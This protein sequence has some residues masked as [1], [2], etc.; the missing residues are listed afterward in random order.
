MSLPV[1]PKDD[2]INEFEK[3][4]AKYTPENCYVGVT[5]NAKQRFEQHNLIGTDGNRKD[6]RIDW[7]LCNSGTEEIT[8]E[9]EKF[10]LDKYKSKI[11][12]G[13]GG[14]GSPTRVYVYR[15]VPGV[16]NETV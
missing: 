12:G 5:E 6:N 1:T 7:R 9:I 13:G 10:F 2:I 3:F 4:I 16:T 14:K 8:R 11:R 15:I